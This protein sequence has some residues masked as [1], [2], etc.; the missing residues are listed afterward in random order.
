[1]FIQ[2]ELSACADI[3]N[4]VA[5][6]AKTLGWKYQ[7]LTYLSTN[8]ATL[9]TSMQ[10]ALQYHPYA[11]SFS[12]IPQAV[13]ASLIPSYKKAGVLIIPV[14]IG[15]TPLSASVPVN[16][17]DFTS[18]G[19]DM[20]KWFINDSAGK[21]NALLAD[22]PAFPILTTFITGFKQQLASGCPGCKTVAFNGTL[23]EVTGGQFAPDIITALK[24][25][26]SVKYVISSDLAF[27]PAL[28][29][30]LSAAGLSGIKIVGAQPEP[31]DL[32]AIQKGTETAT[33]IISDPILGWMV[34]DSAA[35]LSEGVHVLPGDGGS[36]QQLLTSKNIGSD[37]SLSGHIE[38]KSY[39]QQFA[40]LWKES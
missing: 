35:R 20:A 37:A 1:M 15:P 34:D 23:A 21:G 12:G 11:V 24:K 22:L 25:N 9:V 8:P 40:T 7:K 26:P 10:Q 6:G 33:E 2:C 13:W 28:S 27:I 36:P 38:P 16:L 29:S 39:P 31:S 3:G 32:A 5:A 18:G 4:G 30:S 14:V 19:A 17:G